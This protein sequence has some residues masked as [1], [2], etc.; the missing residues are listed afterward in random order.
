M[1]LNL[2]CLHNLDN[3]LLLLLTLKL[4]YCYPSID[5]TP[6]LIGIVAPTNALKCVSFTQQQMLL[7][8][9]D[10]HSKNAL[11]CDFFTQQALHNIVIS[12]TLIQ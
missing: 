1:Y 3:V 5:V 10:L 7:N 6:F 9:S 11:N 12:A 4:N 8:V 2:V